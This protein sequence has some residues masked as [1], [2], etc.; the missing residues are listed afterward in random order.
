MVNSVGKVLEHIEV[1]IMDLDISTAE[2]VDIY[3]YLVA[4]IY[5]LDE[6]FLEQL[7]LL[8]KILS[9]SVCTNIVCQPFSVEGC[10]HFACKNCLGLDK[11]PVYLDNCDNVNCHDWS[12]HSMDELLLCYV[13]MFIDLC[14]YI[15]TTDNMRLHV[16]TDPSSPLWALVKEGVLSDVAHN[17]SVDENDTDNQEFLLEHLNSESIIGDQHIEVTEHLTNGL[18]VTIEDPCNESSNPASWVTR[19]PNA[20]PVIINLTSLKQ[21]TTPESLIQDHNQL[22]QSWAESQQNIHNSAQ[23]HDPVSDRTNESPTL[24]NQNFSTS[25][26]GSVVRTEESAVPAKKL[27]VRLPKPKTQPKIRRGCRCGNAAAVPGKLTCCGQRCPCYV[28][29][30]AC[31]DCRCKGCR[32]PHLPGGKKLLQGINAVI[33]TKTNT[34]V[35][36]PP[37]ALTPMVAA[38][39][40]TVYVL[41]GIKEQRDFPRPKL[42][43]TLPCGDSCQFR[44]VFHSSTHIVGLPAPANP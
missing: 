33:D 38:S 26:V 27:K 24:F 9:C 16:Q 23:I 2:F 42:Y 18:E 32:N 6:D 39:G 25:I 10:D 41:Y 44:W 20:T 8:R 29:A 12:K 40:E 15:C 13:T 36:L 22:V 19:D 7:R 43:P 11:Q 17:D 4:N 28:E 3:R 35:Q 31:F 37:S 34:T 14:K 1:E 5:D 21:S 30:K